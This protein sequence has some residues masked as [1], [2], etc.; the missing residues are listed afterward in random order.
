LLLAINGSH[1]GRDKHQVTG[2]SVISTG[3]K[4]LTHT[5]KGT[6]ADGKPLAA[7]LVFDKQ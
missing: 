3:G 1:A 6:D 7:T 2:Q 5:N 4:A